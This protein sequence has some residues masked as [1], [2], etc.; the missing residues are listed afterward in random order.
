[1]SGIAQ[2]VPKT[3]NITVSNNSGESY[4]N[5]CGGNVKGVSVIAPNEAAVW[6]ISIWDSDGFPLMGREGIV[7]S[8]PIQEE[9][10]AYNDHRKSTDSGMR[11]RIDSSS[12]GTYQIRIFYE[13]G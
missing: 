4:L 8:I 13:A 9:F 6:D 3:A 2:R 11:I 10:Q 12:S 7:G 1:M 5:N